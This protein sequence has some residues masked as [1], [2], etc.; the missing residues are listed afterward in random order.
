MDWR[1][2]W[3][4]GWGRCARLNEGFWFN[5]GSEG[6]KGNAYLRR[7]PSLEQLRE[8]WRVDVE[9]VSRFE[10]FVAGSVQMRVSRG[11]ADLIRSRRRSPRMYPSLNAGSECLN[12][13]EEGSLRPRTC[14]FPPRMFRFDA[15]GP[16]VVLRHFNQYYSLSRRRL[17]LQC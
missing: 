7:K 3:E 5:G 10:L 14:L 8:G 12:I 17:N 16:V 2:R 9:A 1:G 13:G 4:Q 11:S 6:G 15:V